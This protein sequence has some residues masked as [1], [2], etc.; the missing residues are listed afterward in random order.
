[1][2]TFPNPPSRPV[3]PASAGKSDSHLPSAVR[4]ARGLLWLQGAIWA[5][6]AIGFA[7]PTVVTLIH[8]LVGQRTWA[9]FAAAV[10]WLPVM[11]ALTG[12]FAMTKIRLARR[13]GGG[14]ERIRRVVIGVE[15]AMTCLGALITAGVDPA[16]GMPAD[17]VALAAITGGGL[18]LAAALGL[19][20]RQAR[21]YFANPGLATNAAAD[22]AGDSNTAHSAGPSAT[23]SA[24]LRR[25]AGAAICQA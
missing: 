15:I 11:A 14:H 16:G 13:L 20:R 9:S 12:G 8:V 17:M 10:G 3:P 22:G 18:S 25:G 2:P 24:R 4:Y 6:L 19:M 21:R 23:V 7:V 5:L 1:M